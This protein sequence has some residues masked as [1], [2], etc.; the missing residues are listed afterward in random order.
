MA[1][2]NFDYGGDSSYEGYTGGFRSSMPESGA[3]NPYAV[4][5]P[6]HIDLDKIYHLTLEDYCLTPDDIKQ[7]LYGV[8]IIDPATKQE[9]PDENWLTFIKKAISETELELGITIFPSPETRELHDYNEADFF[10]NNFIILN[11]RPVIQVQSIQMVY[12]NQPV[13]SF[14]PEMWKV[15]HLAG[16]VKT[17][18]SDLVNNGGGINS[19]LSPMSL[20]LTGA[21]LFGQ[22]GGSNGGLDMPQIN[23]VTYIAGMLPPAHEFRCKEWEMPEA[24]RALISKVALKD[25]LEIWGEVILKPGIAATSLSLDGLGQSV[26]STLSAENTGATARIMLINKEIDTLTDSLKNYFGGHNAVNI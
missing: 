19:T 9:L 23:A 18:P 17:F 1:I 20:G 3:Y 25:A 2:T 24:L 7:Y 4:N 22:L 10:S 21:S 13:L 6:K 5:N 8:T 16:Q 11:K 26:Q 14:P 12:N 15:Y